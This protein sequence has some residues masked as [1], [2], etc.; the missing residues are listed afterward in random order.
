MNYQQ[1]KSIL[2][3]SFFISFYTLNAQTIYVNEFLASNEN[4]LA[5]EFGD[6]DDWIEI[7]NAGATPVNL[8]NYYISDD[9]ADPTLYQIPASNSAKT[10]VPAGG[11]LLIWADKDLDQ[12]ENHV[13]L[14]LGAGG[15]SV[16]LTAPDG[17]TG[18]DNVLFGPQTDDISYGRETDG[19]A[20]F[21]FFTTPT[22]DAANV[23]SGPSSYHVNLTLPILTANDDGEEYGN[24][25]VNLSSS[26][27]EM[28][29]D[30]GAVFTVAYRFNGVALPDDAIIT[31]AYIQFY[32]EEV[33]VGSADIDIA[34]DG[35][36]DPNPLTVGNF[37]SRTFTST[38]INWEPAPWPVID[39]H[40]T[41][42]Q[43]PDISEVV[44]EV[45]STTGW[46]AENAIVIIMTGSG[47]RTGYAYN[48]DPGKSAVLHIEAEVPLP[49]EPI[50]QIYINELAA[51]GTPYTDESGKREDWIELYNPNLTDVNIGGLFLTDDFGNLDKWQ[52]GGSV[53]VPAGGF[54]T[55]FADDDLM[56]GVLHAGF[57]LKAGGEEVALVQLLADGLTII[58]S[59]SFDEVPF[60]TSYGRSTDGGSNWQLFGETSPDASNSAGLSYL[61]APEGSLAAGLYTGAQ[62]VTLSHPDPMV[63]IYYTT[64]S[65]LPDDGETLYTEPIT[66]NST[67]TIRAIATRSGFADSEVADYIY[68]IDENP[69]MPI[70]NLTTD[71][72]NFFDDEIGIY[73]D[74]TNGRIAYCSSE[75]VNWAQDWERPCNLKMFL[76]DG[77]MVFDV[78][79][80]VEISGACSRGHAMKSLAIN[81]REKEF[82]DDQLNYEVFPQR[83]YD[84]HQRFKIR[85]S[86]QDY[87]RLGFRD[88]V[89]QTLLFK[90]NI[91]IEVQAGRPV[92]F[93]LNGEFWGLY[94][95]REKYVGE[96]FE[97]LYDVN[98]NDLDIIKS[99]GLNYSDVKKGTETDYLALYDF[100]ENADLTNQAD[101]DYFDA[102]VDVNEFLNYWST[103]TYMANYDWPANNLTIWRD[104]ENQ[105]KWRYGVA[106]T[107]GST[108]NF[109]ANN[110]KPEFNTFE[111]INEPN[112][113]SWPN[114]SISTLFL[115]KLLERDEFRHEF[116]QR[117]CTF[118]EVLFPTERTHPLIDSMVGLF[119]PN[120]EAHLDNWAFDNAMGG[121]EP[122]WYEWIDKYKDFWEDRPGYMR[123]H[124]NDF[125]NLD[126]YYDL[127]IN[128]DEST[129]GDVFVNSNTMDIPFDYTG[130][131]FKNIPL[132][133]TA[134]A[135]PGFQFAYWLETGVTD[136][137]IDYIGTA[138]MTLTPIFVPDGPVLTFN[139]PGDIFTTIASPATTAAVSW[140]EPTGSTT[141]ASAVVTI[142]QTS[143]PSNGGDFP[144]GTTTVNYTATDDCGN[145][146]T[147]SFVVTVT[148]DN[149]TLTLACPD[150]IN[151][152]TLPGSTSTFVTWTE[153]AA[154]TTCAAG[155]ESV[156]QTD[157]P[158]NGDSFSIGATTVSYSAV[159]ACGNME[160]C[161]FVVTVPSATSTVSLECPAN[162]TVTAAAGTIV[163]WLEPNGVSDCTIGS[164]T[165]TQTSG[166]P[167]GSFFPAGSYVIIYEA[168]DGCGTS[169]SCS[170]T[171]TVL[172]D[173]GTLTMSCPEV[174]QFV[175]PVGATSM[176]V[177]WSLPTTS[178]TCGGGQQNETCGTV[179]TGF[180]YLGALGDSEYF[181]SDSKIPW[182]LAQANC[183]TFG[184]NLIAIGSVEENDF[185]TANVDVN[186]HIGLNDIETEGVMAW[187]NGEPVGYTNYTG[188][189]NNTE[190]NDYGNWA[191]W[192]FKWGFYSNSVYKYYVME[193]NCSG[194]GGVDLTQTNGP[195][196][197]ST[198]SAGT[199]IVTYEATDDCGDVQ[200]CS[201]NIEVQDNP[202]TISL[203]CP[204]SITVTEDPMAGGAV[205]NWADAVGSTTCSTGGLSI[206]QTGGM[207][208]GTLFPVGV[209]NIVYQA[210]DNC[211]TPMT[212]DFVVTVE[213]DVPSTEYCAAAG[214]SPWQQQIINV[215][216]HTINH[217]SAKEGYADFTDVSTTVNSGSTY[218][219]S[220][221]PKFSYTHWDEYFR[222]WID[223]NGD[224]DFTDAGE[225]VF[226]DIYLAGTDGTDAGP[227]EGTII[228]PS[229]IVTGST[230]MRIAMK[231][232]AFADPCETFNFG[233]VE[234]YTLILTN[235]FAL[236]SNSNPLIEEGATVRTADKANE[237]NTFRIYP[238]PAQEGVYID[239]SEFEGK[240]AQVEIFNTQGQQLVKY[241]FESLEQTPV[242]VNLSGFSNGVY[243]IKVTVDGAA[244]MGERLIVNRVE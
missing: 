130:T 165:T 169:E 27:I 121:D 159:D 235:N 9:P 154:S 178:T 58:D 207:S 102:Q 76:P 52:I 104:R 185:L 196:N 229:G 98:E 218:A 138:N 36:P 7:Y 15:E 100:V 119:Q 77:E 208:S 107:D 126:E 142:T 190:T 66:I 41:D 60:L 64:D 195:N 215:S 198:L 72:D 115:R 145:E 28:V 99:P 57:K 137:V 61:V 13:D 243:T 37:S 8:A 147:C 223:Y 127:T 19:A 139:C 122:S 86:G 117:T 237:I 238:N 197:G 166:S 116:I 65:D 170:F 206:M 228:I 110:A 40:G 187:T 71:P 74:G 242:Y 205:V 202:Q 108:N 81:L 10:T 149:G 144:M 181:R 112:S 56:E 93:Y 134:V 135:D 95:I 194:S 91:D 62:T 34:A 105:S 244:Q 79:A 46:D 173:S 133:L 101:Y 224:F 214:Q 234:D 129:E 125:Y 201:F 20:G 90:G 123:D 49:T 128:F 157:G 47:T 222:V 220:I 1:L 21:T 67:K 233:E 87:Y 200:V 175:L 164:V 70:L 50:D 179:P 16:V 32:A 113:N 168:I 24:G 131:Y 88:V 18:I 140:T 236:N 89:N 184:G 30:G 84:N 45:I 73:V 210:T 232:D 59:I 38:S 177:N 53:T 103:M 124:M 96:H 171:I 192:S 217:D 212:C 55:F 132:R 22:P 25:S 2:I 120:L 189:P 17:V 227:V 182:T 221:T 54:T 204:T 209:Y 148:V 162:I 33:Q 92:L 167:S 51:F 111:F 5:D 109:L 155:G 26:D 43:T 14:K 211:G 193:L 29:Q 82:G 143:G 231:K 11:Y 3:C 160:T 186:V 4:N 216:F 141:C 85:N 188:N 97:E 63:D 78:N 161:S 239:L 35:S 180:S 136:A 176:P 183:E 230:H 23:V 44:Q 150:H 156:T 118:I 163:D 226:E 151:V 158:L 203:E 213:A 83:D 31:N 219:I 114:N 42:Q 106:D 191:P 241:D 94:N 75:P 225:L 80:G 12:G 146:E 172:D 199:Y 6:F 153:P 69:N 39:A 174:L 48:K 68:L 240:T 152:T